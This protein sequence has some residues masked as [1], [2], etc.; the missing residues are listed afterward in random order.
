MVNLNCGYESIYDIISPQQIGFFHKQFE[1][2]EI[3]NSTAG[4]RNLE[5]KSKAIKDLAMSEQL[6]ISVL[7]YLP[8]TPKLVRAIYFNKTNQ[9]NWLVPWHQD[10]TVAVSKK[11]ENDKWGPWSVKDGI[12]HVQPPLEVLNQMVTFRIHLDNTDK[13]NGA[14]KILP[15]SHRL[16]I[17]SHSDILKYTKGKIAVDCNATAGSALVIHPLLLHAS[18]KASKPTQRRILH[19]EYSSYKLPKGIEWA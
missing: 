17:L 14:L 2:I 7:K 9:N 6:L 16:G 8:E 12:H 15:N 18:S 10:K 11:F 13:D 19:F 5:T 4:I 3:K 1:S